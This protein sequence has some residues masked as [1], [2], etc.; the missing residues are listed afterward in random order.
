MVQTLNLGLLQPLLHHYYLTLFS[1]SDFG[2]VTLNFCLF[3]CKRG[4]VSPTSQNCQQDSKRQYTAQEL[5]LPGLLEERNKQWLKNPRCPE[6]RGRA[7]ATPGQHQTAH[8]RQPGRSEQ[9][10]ASTASLDFPALPSQ[11]PLMGL[12]WRWLVSGQQR[13]AAILPVANRL[14][15][16]ESKPL[17]RRDVIIAVFSICL[18]GRVVLNRLCGAL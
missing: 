13:D 4:E 16:S 12:L 10:P 6:I 11:G 15:H 8:T 18:V 2:K 14:P 17:P 3:F 1:L 5:A 9:S 7:G